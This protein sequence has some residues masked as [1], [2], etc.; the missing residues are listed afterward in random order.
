MLYSNRI[1][2]KIVVI[3]LNKEH[4]EYY[5]IKYVFEQKVL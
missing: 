4:S 3:F 5:K 2:K 1:E